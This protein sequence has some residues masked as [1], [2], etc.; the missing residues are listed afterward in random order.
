MGEELIEKSKIITTLKE[1]ISNYVTEISKLKETEKTLE[2]EIRNLHN[3][4]KCSNATNVTLKKAG[5]ENEKDLKLFDSK[6]KSFETKLSTLNKE[7][8]K[9]KKKKK[10]KKK[11]KKKKKKS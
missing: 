11:K 6:V 4:L 8:S 7:K 5:V 10:G 9:K 1:E 2:V 3:K